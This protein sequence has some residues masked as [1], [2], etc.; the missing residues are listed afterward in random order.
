MERSDSEI[1]T[2]RSQM[3]HG[4]DQSRTERIEEDKTRQQS[5]LHGGARPKTTKMN[6]ASLF[7]EMRD[8]NDMMSPNTQ[9]SSLPQT[10]KVTFSDDVKKDN[11]K[12]KSYN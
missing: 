9:S 11:K 6:T 12:L 7:A 8:D 1:V 4:T 10:I 5:T 3:S 2:T